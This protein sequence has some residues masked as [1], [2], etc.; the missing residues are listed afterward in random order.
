MIHILLT[1]VALM[2]KFKLTYEQTIKDNT[3]I[4]Q[5]YY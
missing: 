2:I 1:D 5:R 3:L 4:P